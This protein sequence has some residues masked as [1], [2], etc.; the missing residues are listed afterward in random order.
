[1]PEIMV[2]FLAGAV[3]LAYLVA[4][5]FFLRFWRKTGDP[6]FASFALAFL[7]LAFARVFVSVVGDQDERTTVAYMLRVIAHLVIMYAILGKNLWR[8]RRRTG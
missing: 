4:A 5:V 2:E 8:S 6:L 7:V 1:M 3:T